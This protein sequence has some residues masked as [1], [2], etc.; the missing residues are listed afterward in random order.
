[1]F[2]E[3]MLKKIEGLAGTFLWWNIYYV[4]LCHDAVIGCV[5]NILS[6]SYFA[7]LINLCLVMGLFMCKLPLKTVDM[8]LI[9][10][11]GILALRKGG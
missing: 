3:R 7:K 11:W 2:N 1:M 9:K 6:L 10:F 8:R 4:I 5:L